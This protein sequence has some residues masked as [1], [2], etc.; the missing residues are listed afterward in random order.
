MET[1]ALSEIIKI[2]IVMA[3]HKREIEK[4]TKMR[5]LAVY[6]A[7]V[8]LVSAVSSAS[9]VSNANDSLVLLTKTLDAIEFALNFFHQ[10]HQNLNLDAVIGTR[11]IEGK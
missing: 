10:E 2:K 1:Y 3:L 5:Y 9:L 8:L 6:F 7:W 4:A 11:M